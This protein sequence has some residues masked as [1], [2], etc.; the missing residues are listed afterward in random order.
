[1]CG[2]CGVYDLK[3]S[4]DGFKTDQAD[5]K[6]LI[7]KM[8]AAQAHRGPDDQGIWLDGPAALGHVRLSII[9]LSEAGHQPMH[10]KDRY[11][12]VYNG[13][14]YNYI[15]LREEL[16]RAGYRFRT[17]TDTEVV[18]AAY[19]CWGE[20][21]QS[22]FNGFW[23]FA[24]YDKETR[25]L[26]LSRDRYG[27]KPLYYTNSPGY[28]IF[29]S[30]IKALLQDEHIPRRA[31]DAVVFDYLVNGFVD[32]GPET[33]FEGIYRLPAGHSMVID[34]EGRQ[35][36]RQYY[37]LDYREKL[38]GPVSRDMVKG[39][40]RLFQSSVKLRLRADVPV[41][42]CL[43]GGLDSS[44]IV[45]ESSRQLHKQGKGKD[46]KTFSSC[47][48]GDVND[49]RIY[50][51][52]V[53]RETGV[54][55]HYTYP[56]GD[57]LYEDLDHLIYTQDEPFVSTSMYASYRVMKL[58]H[59]ND[60]KVLLD[61]QGADEILCGYR[62]ARVYYIRQLVKVGRIK[63][64]A[65]EFF[66]YLPYMRKGKN[67]SL[68]AEWNMICQFLGK[69]SS[70]DIRHRYLEESF[71]GR[72]LTN[73]YED[74]DRFLLNDFDKVVL[75][76]LLRYVD[77]NSMAFSIEDRLPFLDY[78][79]VEYAMGLPLNAKIHN[80]YSKAIMRRALDMPDLVRK[81]KDKIGFYT[82]ENSWMARHI[83][84]YRSVFTNP[85]FRAGKYINAEKIIADWDH[86]TH[87]KDDI[88]LFRYICLEK[89]MKCFDV[90]S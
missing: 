3:T 32:C 37:Q 40:R 56:D 81:R 73:S 54:D 27:V 35:K 31:N 19:D 15:E 89:W 30:E 48:Q 25:R 44:A 13:E 82:P 10:Y 76:A 18:L 53:T 65:K 6:E 22:R 4:Q 74:N 62:K 16:I 83:D 43:S 68:L 67:V 39:F 5:K 78:R 21:C 80:G 57:S 9:D 69:T 38:E 72:S 75:P 61:G 8:N 90:S 50:I 33:F 20:E 52:A 86:L 26:F 29:A 12:L 51:E 46:Q 49:E 17:R 59:E 34:E 1:M 41:G 77:R 14:I 7:N 85:D 84:E 70:K 2:I 88:G 79:L 63:E 71:A 64:A 45:C 55:A 66:Y 42:S 87:G 36:I 11:C 47:Y 28:F 58:A 23:A 24:L 60:I